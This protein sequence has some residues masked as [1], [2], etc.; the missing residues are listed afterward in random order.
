MGI[1]EGSVVEFADR[2]LTCRDCGKPFTWT[3]GEQTFYTEKGLVN[4]PA[5]CPECRAARK[6]RLGLEPPRMMHTI[7][8]AE[9]GQETTVPFVPRN[10]RP[11]LCSSCF[12]KAKVAQES[13]EA[14]E[15]IPES[16]IA[17]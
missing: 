10:G 8:C 11:V 5:R 17:D 15:A 13:I 3:A 14:I 7:V 9:C 16:A 1:Q 6:A 2:T 4:E 12:A